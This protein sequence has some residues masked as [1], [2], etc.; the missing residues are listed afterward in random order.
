MLLR[1]SCSNYCSIR[2]EAVL[3]LKPSGS[4]DHP[5][6]IVRKGNYSALNEIAIYGANASGK[7]KLFRAMTIAVVIIRQSN[8]RQFNELIP[9]VP[10]KFDEV[11]PGKPTGFEFTFVAADDRKYTYGFSADR[12]RV[13]DEYL[14]RYTASNHKS[15]VF[16]RHDEKYDYSRSQKKFLEPIQRMNT[17][18]KLFLATATNW[19]A[20][21]TSMPYKWLSEGIDTFTN[22]L[23]VPAITFN[24]YR[25]HSEKYTEFTR[26]LLREADIN[27]SGIE[28]ESRKISD[29]GSGQT[30]PGFMVNGM[31][32]PPQEQYEI[33]ISTGHRVTG[34]DGKEKT[35][36]LLLSEESLG[37]C[38]LF[39][40]APLIKD[41]LDSG[42]TLVID[43]IDRSMHPA[44]VKYLVD[45]FRRPEI[46]RHGAQLIF[47]THEMT[48]LA[49]GSLRHDQIYFTDKDSESAATSLYSLNEFRLGRN[50]DIEKD[51]LLGRYGA[52]P[53]LKTEELL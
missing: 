29:A 41:A 15:L 36:Q 51:Y 40:F 25:E 4:K 17:P 18:N 3:S 43:E 13:H 27:I 6:N 50:E 14:Y 33:K 19:N 52:V 23:N 8:F 38:Q 46:N 16:E 1:F 44:I 28:V 9:V 45:M 24:M 35:Y 32:V 20:E 11:S 34:S 48:L 5:E 31:P 26:A 2:D 12:T 39:Y 37:T 53:F 7:S 21:P 47:T 42:K 30:A 49:S 22:D 10:F